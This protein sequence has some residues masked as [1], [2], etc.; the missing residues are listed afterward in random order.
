MRAVKAGMPYLSK[1]CDEEKLARVNLPDTGGAPTLAP[2][3][4]CACDHSF[5]ARCPSRVGGFGESEQAL[6]SREQETGR[7]G[8]TGAGRRRRKNHP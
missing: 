8:P 1:L 2:S 3:S 5:P 4:L 7:E 6:R